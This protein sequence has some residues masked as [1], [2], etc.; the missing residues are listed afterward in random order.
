MI[1][2]LKHL[3]S[4]R[5]DDTENRRWA[6]LEACLHRGKKRDAQQQSLEHDENPATKRHRAD[7]DSERPASFEEPIEE[8]V[9]ARASEVAQTVM[10]QWP[11]RISPKHLARLFKR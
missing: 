5:N 7:L 6:R 3:L 11:D 10:V 9:G 2:N 8:A 4:I 1:K